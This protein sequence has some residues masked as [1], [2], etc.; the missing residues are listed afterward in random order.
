M[1]T[2]T[3]T[4]DHAP[5]GPN[6]HWVPPPANGH[7]CRITG[8]T[9]GRFYQLLKAAGSRIRTVSLKEDGRTRGTRL[10]HVPSLLAYLDTL[11]MGSEQKGGD[12]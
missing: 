10:V 8:L 5:G 6:P 4:S 7:R 12:R 11:P 9:H 1:D 2:S 3:T